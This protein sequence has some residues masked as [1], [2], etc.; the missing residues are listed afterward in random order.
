AEWGMIR[1]LRP[2]YEMIAERYVPGQTVVVA[3]TL[4]LA[5]RI[6]QEKLG[7]PLASVH[8][9]PMVFR[10]AAQPATLPGL[11]LAPWMPRWYTHSIYWTGDNFVIDPV[12]GPGL[13]AF[14][15]ELGLPPIRRIYDSWFHSPQL[16]LGLFPDWFAPPQPDWPPNLRLTG[17]P[18]YDEGDVKPLDPELEG[19]L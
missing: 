8:L 3:G 18:L 19:F 14:R 1:P 9:Q 5:A 17:F 11:F 7:V 2:I 6:A 12:V 4:A 15:A 16:V 10:S 13:N